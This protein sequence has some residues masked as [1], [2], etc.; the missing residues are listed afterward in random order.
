MPRVEGPEERV[1]APLHAESRGAIPH[2]TRQTVNRRSVPE[3]TI[4]LLQMLK[5]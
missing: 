5:E 2:P 1:E 3:S 4:R